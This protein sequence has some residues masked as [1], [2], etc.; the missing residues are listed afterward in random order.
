MGVVYRR[1]RAPSRAVKHRLDDP[2]QA[3]PR[4]AY[5]PAVPASVSPG[6][7]I[8]APAVA[9]PLRSLLSQLISWA[10]YATGKAIPVHPAHI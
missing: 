10:E 4:H 7:L 9:S 2:H 8:V 5:I 1:E 3:I 6:K